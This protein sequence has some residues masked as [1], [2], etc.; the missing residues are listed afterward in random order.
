MF[1]ETISRMELELKCTTCKRNVIAEEGWVKFP[2]PNCGET[3]IVR[4]SQC[5]RLS[6][7]YKCEKCG[8]EGP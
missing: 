1:I 7:P 5:R 6:N 3:I 4:C 2:C 8:F